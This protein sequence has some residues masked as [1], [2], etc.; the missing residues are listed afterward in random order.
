MP[1]GVNSPVRAMQQIGR[2]PI[3]IERGEGPYIWDVDG[4]RYVDWVSSWGPLILGHADPLVVEAIRQAADR[5]TSYGAPTAGEVDLATEVVSRFPSVEMVRMTSSGT[6]ATM[7]ALRLARAATGRSKIVKFAGA[8]HGHVDGL[9]A[10]GGSGLATAGVP[11]SP[12]VTEAQASDTVIVPWN[13]EEAVSDAIAQVRPAAVIAEPIPANMGVVP[14]DPG[15]LEHLR[16]ATAEAGALLVL[17]EVISGFRVARGGAQELLGVEGDLTVMGKVMGGGLPAAAYG[18]PR[19]LMQ[20]I[21]PAG[22]VYQAG[23]LSGNPLA[24]AAGLADPPQARRCRLSRARGDHGAARRRPARGGRGPA[25]AGGERSRS[26]HRLL[27]RRPGPGLRGRERLRHRRLRPLLPGPARSRCLPARL[28]VRSLVPVPRPRRSDDRRDDRGGGRGLSRSRLS[29]A[30]LTSR[31]RMA[32]TGISLAPL[33]ALLRDG[34]NVIA[35]HITDSDEEPALGALAAAGPR[36]A[37]APDEYL[38]LVEAIR[39]GY[40]LHYESSRLIQG[41]DPDLRLLAGDYLYALGLERLAARGDLD[42]VGELADLISLVAQIHAE[43]E[44][45]PPDDLVRALWLAATAAVAAGASPEHLEAKEKLRE[46]YP[47]AGESL[48]SAAAETAVEAGLGDALAR[49]A[50]SIGFA[51]ERFPDRG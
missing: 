4:N 16:D 1:G 5:G 51:R 49:A 34:E 24:V 21:A 14:P 20:R 43:G 44:P 10:E 38:L 19:E 7:S 9:L 40:L 45:G 6:E 33:A 35:P 23:T 41:A 12:G 39:E 29:I 27:L 3:F 48:A 32:S 42:A 46:G 30:P 26:G 37:E 36:A 25:R 11:A 47:D 28:A 22:D 17:D 15:F 13:D 2:S 31:F 8:Y 50:E 18:G